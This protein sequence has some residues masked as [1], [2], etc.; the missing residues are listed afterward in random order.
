M[1]FSRAAVIWLVVAA[2]LGTLIWKVAEGHLLGLAPSP[3][4]KLTPGAVRDACLKGL[5]QN[6]GGSVTGGGNEGPSWSGDRWV[7]TSTARVDGD[8]LRFTCTLTGGGATGTRTIIRV[9][10]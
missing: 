3:L 9:L 6:L 8:P 5:A 1:K 2:V 10:N 4:A 7:W